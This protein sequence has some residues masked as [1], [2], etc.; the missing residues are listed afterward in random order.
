MTWGSASGRELHPSEAVLRHP[1]SP[2]TPRAAG[3]AQG[4][5]LMRWLAGR[6]CTAAS[7][8]QHAASELEAGQSSAYRVAPTHGPSA[9]GLLRRDNSALASGAARDPP[10]PSILARKVG[11]SSQGTD[12]TVDV[13]GAPYPDAAEDGSLS[14]DDTAS[15]SAPAASFWLR[16][17]AVEDVRPRRVLGF[18]KYLAVPAAE[19]ARR[20]RRF[21]A[22][23]LAASLAAVLALFLLSCLGVWA[24]AR[25]LPTADDLPLAARL[26][27][28]V[29]LAR[30]GGLLPPGP[31]GETDAA[32][33]AAAPELLDT[34]P[35][36][37]RE[38]LALR[39][40]TALRRGSLLRLPRSLHDAQEMQAVLSVLQSVA[41]GRVTSF[42]VA[43]YLV[44]Q[45]FM[46]PGVLFLN[47]MAGSLLPF[48]SAF[49]VVQACSTLGSCIAYGLAAWLLV[50][51]AHSLWPR[52]LTQFSATVAHNR[53]DLASYIVA[54]RMSPVA[55][56]FFINLASPIV[57]VPFTTYTIATFAGLFP[58]NLLLVKAGSTIASIK[59]MKDL[60]SPATV[61]GMVVMMLA[62]IFPVFYKRWM[63][64]AGKPTPA[65]A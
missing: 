29:R 7:P 34:V 60:Y 6:A 15:P 4:G 39:A 46:I 45:S 63:S 40:A 62:A 37:A 28:E 22:T 38:A 25:S 35:D 48:W 42:F 8:R 9:G 53:T 44:M 51:L 58:G 55:P 52:Q 31:P 12:A 5:F 16:S 21:H 23:H 64:R 30:A 65:V 43:F 61:L 17:L 54:I 11:K 41:P 24:L 3:K 50:D 59:Q 20:K 14:S 13:E 18:P 19:A 32:L 47:P 1:A 56:N 33:R 49:A 36:P 10:G 57:G 2:R 27:L 26:S